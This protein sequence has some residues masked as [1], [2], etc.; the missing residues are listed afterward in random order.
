[1]AIGFSLV[2]LSPVLSFVTMPALLSPSLAD[3]IV[4]RD[5]EPLAMK[6][7]T[8]C[9]QLLLVDQFH[10][11]RN[12]KNGLDNQCKSCR[13]TYAQLNPV[14]VITRNMLG[15]AKRTARK[16]SVP[17]DI[18]IDFIRKMVGENAQFASHCPIFKTRLEWSCR[19]SDTNGPLPNSPSIDRIDPAKGYVK[20]NVW[21]I[22]NR[23]NTIKSNATHEELKL[24]T[25]AVG[26]AIVDSL[27]W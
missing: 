23:A 26:R 27:D 11:S 10:K 8:K 9:K 14:M 12:Q 7:C 21:I 20:G 19:R 25:E 13:N 5:H 6:Q 17:F 18:D 22:S 1:M 15:S 4:K 3:A 2:I 24:V 16:K